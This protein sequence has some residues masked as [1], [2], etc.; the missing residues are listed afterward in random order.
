MKTRK[1]SRIKLRHGIWYNAKTDSYVIRG[2]SGKTYSF[3][4]MDDAEAF[5]ESIKQE[6]LQRKIAEERESIKASDDKLIEEADPFPFNAAK[7][8]G[9]DDSTDP[10]FLNRPET[11]LNDNEAKFLLAYYRDGLNLREISE[12]HKLSK[13]RIG[14]IVKLALRKTY[15]KV[16]KEQGD[17]KTKERLEILERDRRDLNAYRAQLIEIFRANGIYG[18]DMEIEFGPVTSKKK[19]ILG[20]ESEILSR[21]TDRLGLS[22]R[23]ANCLRRAGI[24]TVGELISKTERDVMRIRNLGKKSF[25]EVKE[26]LRQLGLSLKEDA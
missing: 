15:L 12:I 13:A 19:E 11:Y 6:R 8:A 17:A 4:S 21:R 23:S 26:R 20:I 16:K 24:M 10:D 25:I 1:E 14:Q 2:Q 18:E 7:A 22:M 5:Y 9:L 3:P